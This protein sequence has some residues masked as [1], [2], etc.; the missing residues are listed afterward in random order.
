MVLL[1]RE[2]SD[3]D[4]VFEIEKERTASAAAFAD[5]YIFWGDD[6]GKIHWGSLTSG[7]QN[8]LAVADEAITLLGRPAVT[9]AAIY[10]RWSDG[11]VVRYLS[12]A[13]PPEQW[14]LKEF[15]SGRIIATDLMAVNQLVFFGSR[16]ESSKW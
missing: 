9:P 2:P 12:R 5:D 3:E 1:A 15:N 11:M 13:G 10:S 6:R 4:H 8:H 14:S 16:V 7:E